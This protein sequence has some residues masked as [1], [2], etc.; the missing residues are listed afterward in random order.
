M[1]LVQ[2]QEGLGRLLIDPSHPFNLLATTKLWGLH[3]SGWLALVVA[4]FH[5]PEGGELRSAENCW[6][7]PM[8]YDSYPHQAS[9]WYS[10]NDIML[11]HLQPID[12]HSYQAEYWKIPLL[13]M[14]PADNWC[15][16]NHLLCWW[17]RQRGE[18]RKQQRESKGVCITMTYSAPWWTPTNSIIKTQRFSCRASHDGFKWGTCEFRFKPY[19]FLSIACYGTMVSSLQHLVPECCRPVAFTN[20]LALAYACSGWGRVE[21]N[22]PKEIIHGIKL[23]TCSKQPLAN[24]N[25]SEKQ[26]LLISSS[27]SFQFLGVLPF[28]Y[29]GSCGYLTALI[30]KLW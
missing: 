3:G 4:A 1:V 5:S 22:N 24:E 6:R 19:N 26:R 30:E 11:Q 29:F 20:A 27:Q 25:L 17:P 10:T 23:A 9:P 15:F 2:F 16:F 14:Q 13:D 12:F 28:L 7:C 18:W 8:S 21:K